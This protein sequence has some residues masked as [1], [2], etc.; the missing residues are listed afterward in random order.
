MRTSTPRRLP[1]EWE[2]HIATVVAWP[3]RLSVWEEHLQQ[4][5]AETLDL[6]KEIAIDERVVLAVDPA[7]YGDLVDQARDLNADV[8]AIPLDDCWARDIA[9]VFVL[10]NGIDKL[11]AID[12][13]FNAWGEKFEP[14]DGD[15]SFGGAVSEHLGIARE[16]SDL[17][18][19]G[20]SITTDGAGTAILVETSV[21][22]QNR[23]PGRTRADVEQILG[24]HLGIE[25][26]I[27]LPY[28]LLGDTDT[29]GHVDNVAVYCAEGRVLVQSAPSARHPD[30]ERMSAN[31]SILTRARDARGRQLDLVEV[32]WLPV[33]TLDRSRPCSYVNVYPTNRRVLVPAVGSDTD[34]KAAELVSEAFG[35]RP[36]V[37]VLSNALSF[38]GGGPHCMTMQIP[39]SE[40]LQNEGE[41]N[42][43]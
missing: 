30:A 25:T 28:G 37:S 31:H 42:V 8:V 13:A 21:L 40:A 10:V 22:N 38:G 39:A 9:P 18:L 43:R 16:A 19:E 17:V 34:D 5:R 2:A 32:P 11:H 24:V 29:D 36:P 23:N 4:G 15:A 1:A 20:G 3:G 35:G 14:Y 41:L 26:V 6:A 7:H 12:F 27:W 33:S